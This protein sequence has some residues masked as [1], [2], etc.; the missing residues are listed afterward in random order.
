MDAITTGYRVGR[1]P[2]YWIM[3]LKKNQKK[4]SKRKER[5]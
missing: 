4:G 3:G 5:R 2:G 1:L